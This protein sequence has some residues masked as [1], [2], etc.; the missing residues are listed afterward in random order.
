M[1][2]FL[3]AG[4]AAVVSVRHGLA[5]DRL[6]GSGR[7]DRVLLRDLGSGANAVRVPGRPVRRTPRPLERLGAR[8]NERHAH[9]PDPE[10]LGRY[11]AGDAG[12]SRQ[13]RLPPRRLFDL[14]PRGQQV[15]AG[16]CLPRAH[17]L[18]PYLLG[19]GSPPPAVPLPRWWAGGGPPPFPRP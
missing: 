18:R 5:R 19:S 17:A 13:Q 6:R 12:G 4:L 10:L 11:P 8:G 9:E 2:P 1:Q 7:A 3:P 16:T 14:E 15:A